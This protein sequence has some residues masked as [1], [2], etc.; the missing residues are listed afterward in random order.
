MGKMKFFRK[1]LI[2]LTLILVM[3]LS[4]VACGDTGKTPTGNGQNVTSTSSTA[5]TASAARNI[6]LKET[7]KIDFPNSITFNITAS[8]SSIITQLRVH[9][10]VDMQNVASVVSEGWAQFTP[11]K[12]VNTSWF[13]DMRKSALPP[14]AH[15]EYW[16]TALDASGNTGSTSHATL[17]FEDT[18]FQWQSINKEPVTIL[19]YNGDKTFANNLMNAAQDGLQRIE[20]NVGAVPQ[21]SVKIYIYASAQELQSAQLFAQV[22]EGGVTFFGY[23]IIAIGVPLDQLSFGERAVP[24]ELTHW[25]VNQVTFN[26]YGASLPVWLNEGLATYGESTV[27]NPD[28][29]T[30]LEQAIQNNQL[31]S[32]RSLSSPFSAIAQV[33]FTSYGESTSIVNFMINTYGKEKMK[34]LLAVFQNG[35]T[36]DEALKQVYGFDQDGL[37]K[38]WLQSIGVT[39]S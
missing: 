36:Y 5:A 22:W 9:Y 33:A 14:D 34:E 4:A 2:S 38:V 32:V 21:G 37:N 24:H 10:I 3:S 29:Q 39:T 13:W 23:N 31:L 30:A 27:L 11:G 1:H 25:I 20:N 8:S 17:V 6:A 16:W 7:V 12:K 26:N 28:Y 15:V 19:W 18:R 35:A